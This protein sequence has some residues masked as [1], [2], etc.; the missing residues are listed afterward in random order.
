MKIP[1]TLPD[2]IVAKI[3]RSEPLSKTIRRIVIKSTETQPDLDPVLLELIK[4]T[5]EKENEKHFD[6]FMKPIYKMA[7]LQALASIVTF[8]S[9]KFSSDE[10]E[11]LQGL[12]HKIAQDKIG[13]DK[14]FK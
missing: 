9:S 6:E 4:E 7:Y 1:V 11:E 14:I 13:I 2:E 10:I 5:V 12:A 3:K 8:Y